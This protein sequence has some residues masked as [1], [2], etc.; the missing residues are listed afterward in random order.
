M[1]HVQFL[2][3]EELLR[4]HVTRDPSSKAWQQIQST[5][6]SLKNSYIEG[7]SVLRLAYSQPQNKKTMKARLRS[8]RS[9]LISTVAAINTGDKAIPRPYE[10]VKLDEI[11]GSWDSCS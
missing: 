3:A 7:Q 5:A 1:S 9:I 8:A 10:V 6:A 2:F 11:L 4:E